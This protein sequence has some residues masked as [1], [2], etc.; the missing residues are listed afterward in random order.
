MVDAAKAALDAAWAKVQSAGSTANDLQDAKNKQANYDRLV[1]LFNTQQAA[2]QAAAQA[3]AAADEAAYEKVQ[4]QKQA[5][6]DADAAAAKAAQAAQDAANA[7]AAHKAAAE[8]AAMQAQ[9]DAAVA[10]AKAGMAQIPDWA[11]P[12]GLGVVGLAVVFFMRK[13]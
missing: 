2:A 5:Q 13:K 10:A 3:Q 9:I 6:A 4:A 12:V 1:K 11:L 7:D 8:K